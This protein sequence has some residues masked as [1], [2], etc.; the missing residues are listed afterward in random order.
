MIN[1]HFETYAKTT[2]AGKRRFYFR[3]VGENH[4]KIFPSEG[5]NTP[6]A[7]DERIAAIKA[8]AA[9]AEVRPGKP[10]RPKPIAAATS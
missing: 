10:P 2:K 3:G 4:E 7:R 5:Y 1:W 6:S 8:G 9:T